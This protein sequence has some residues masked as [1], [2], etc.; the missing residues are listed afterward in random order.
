MAYNDDAKG[1]FELRNG[2][3]LIMG[4]KREN[5]L[6]G[7]SCQF[8]LIFGFHLCSQKHKKKG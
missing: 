3:A 2:M 7:K 4:Q 5:F 6:L 1:P 8:F